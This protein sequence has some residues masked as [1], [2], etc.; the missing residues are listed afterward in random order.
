MLIKNHYRYYKGVIFLVLQFLPRKEKDMRQSYY[1]R[2][3]KIGG[4]IYV[5]FIDP[6]TQR[7]IVRT[8][9]TDNEKKANA[10]AQNWLANGLP[11]KPRSNNKLK[12]IPFCD[13]LHQFWDFQKSDYFRELETMGKEPH[14]EHALEMQRAV[15]RYYRPYFNEKLLCQI[16]EVILQKF[17]VYLKLEKSYLLP[18]LIQPVM[19]RLLLYAMQ[20]AKKL[21]NILILTLYLERV[22]NLKNVEFLNRKKL[23][24]YSSCRGQAVFHAW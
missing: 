23:I 18:L 15:N 11:D 19:R 8:T 6:Q 14:V 1:L 20:N 9:G 21:F 16:D 2:Q 10:I 3:R 17:I 4:T 22:E 5:T 7:Q 13:Y 12:N 24:G